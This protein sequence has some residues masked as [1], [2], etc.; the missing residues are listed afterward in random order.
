MYK[1]I[2]LSGIGFLLTIVSNLLSQ[3]KFTSNFDFNG[4]GLTGNYYQ[5]YFIDSTGVI[6]CDSLTLSFSKQYKQLV[7]M[8]QSSCGT[9]RQ[10]H[11]SQ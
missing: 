10:E 7:S 8:F 1:A 2:L 5:G 6:N 11:L 9:G 3:E 4:D